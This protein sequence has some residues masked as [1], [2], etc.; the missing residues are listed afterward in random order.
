MSNAPPLDAPT[1]RKRRRKRELVIKPMLEAP[2]QVVS[3]LFSAVKCSLAS[4]VRRRD[5]LILL[6]QVVVATNQMAKRVSMLAKELLLAKLEAEEALPTLD[7]SFYSALYTSLRNGKWKYTGHDALLARRRAAEQQLGSVMVQ[8][9]ALAGRKLAAELDTHYR[10]HYERFYRRWKRICGDETKEDD[11][12]YLL[13]PDETQLEPLIRAAWAMRRDLERKEARGFALFPE[14]SARVSYVTLDATCIAHLYRRLH[15]WSF[16]VEGKRPGTTKAQP[17]NDVA[18]E[19][20]SATFAELFDL[21]RTRRLR[22]THH[23]RYALHT[24]GVGLALSFGKWVHSVPK[25]GPGEHKRKK[26]KAEATTKSVTELR[27]G[28]AH[29][30]QNKTIASL[31]ELKGYTVRCVDPGVRRI[32]TSIDLLTEENDARSSV[33]S[34]RSR[35]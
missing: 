18:M 31:D 3:E 28:F 22:K 10:R 32:Y 33:M 9:M 34:M 29:S 12:S 2:G 16:R 8:A 23:F 25:S 35:T 6:E 17:I 5:F 4:V 13:D 11:D 1:V 21:P 27:T 7:Q 20:G 26:S 19:H 15:P 14:T 24:D 30:A